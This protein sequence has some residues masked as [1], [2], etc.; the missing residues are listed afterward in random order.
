MFRN[1]SKISVVRYQ[2]LNTHLLYNCNLLQI[3]LFYEFSELIY[4]F[5]NISRKNND[6]RSEIIYSGHV[7][8]FFLLML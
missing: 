5:Y 8:L 6:T 4:L 1:I 7:S 2:I 3:L